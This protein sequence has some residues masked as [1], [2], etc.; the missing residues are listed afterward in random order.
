MKIEKSSLSMIGLV[1]VL[2]CAVV[3]AASTAQ[4]QGPTIQGA[5]HP[6]VA[7]GTTPSAWLGTSF[8]YQG[9]LEDAGGPVTGSC[10]FNFTLWDDPNSGSQI[11]PDQSMVVSVD[12]GYFSV[13]LDFGDV[14]DGT[15]LYLW[16]MTRCPS[17]VGNYTILSPRVPLSAAPYAH[18]LRPGAQVQ[19]SGE[20]VLNVVNNSTGDGV[21]AYNNGVLFSD[22][23]LEG[24]NN[25]SGSGVYGESASGYGVYGKGGSYGLYSEGALLVDGFAYIN[26]ELSWQE[27]TGYVSVPAAAFGPEDDYFQYNNDGWVLSPSDQSSY[28]YYAPVQLPHGATIT[29]MT[30][31]WVDLSAAQDATCALKVDRLGAGAPVVVEIA[32]VSSTGSSGDGTSSTSTIDPTYGTID[33]SQYIYYIEWN[34]PDMIKGSGVIIEYTFSEPY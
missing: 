14:Y 26:G 8:T 16:I 10:D 12:D 34:L 24:Y 29:A 33:N 11:G 25:S 9:R 32:A 15:A 23:A 22:A 1:L 7:L 13:A 27:K 21:R 20:Y 5:L 28:L 2:G 17:G 4:A 3:L 18:S 30:F 31:G 6:Q 19:G